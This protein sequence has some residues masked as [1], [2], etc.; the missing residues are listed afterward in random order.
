[1]VHPA[2]HAR[3]VHALGG[4]LFLHRLIPA[5]VLGCTRL[6]LCDVSFVFWA[7]PTGRHVRT[8]FFGPF[9]IGQPPSTSTFLMSRTDSTRYVDV[10][11]SGCHRRWHQPWCSPACGASLS[12]QTT[13]AKE[14]AHSFAASAE[15]A[16]SLAR[17][18]AADHH[19][20]SPSVM[21]NLAGDQN[22]DFREDGILPNRDPQTGVHELL[23]RL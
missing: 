16:N 10:P 8:T 22:M 13:P 1:M 21:A 19:T 11:R 7:P 2:Y 15:S 20:G 6:A 18:L 12:T 5:A 9:A 3:A 14:T 4:F 17:T 23:D